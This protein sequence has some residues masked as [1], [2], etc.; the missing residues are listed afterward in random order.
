[1]IVIMDLKSETSLINQ[2]DV[3]FFRYVGIG[4]NGVN[5]AT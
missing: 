2:L 5:V 4:G 1:M 3:C